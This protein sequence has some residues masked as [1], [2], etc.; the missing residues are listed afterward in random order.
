[1]RRLFVLIALLGCGASE[2][3]PNGASTPAATPAAACSVTG[4]VTRGDVPSAVPVH[5][6]ASQPVGERE[7]RGV[8]EDQAVSGSDGTFSFGAPCGS[9]VQLRFD[10]WIWANEPPEV[11][12][13]PAPSPLSVVLVPERAAHLRLED[14]AGNALTGELT[15]ITGEVL[16]VPPEGVEVVGL[17][18]GHIAGTITSAGHAPRTWRMNRSDEFAEVEPRHFEVTVRMGAEAPLWVW[19]PDPRDVAGVWC[20]VDGARGDG[21]KLRD[22]AWYCAC[23]GVDRV[24]IATKLWDVGLVREVEGKD[25]V[26]E[27]WPAPVKQCLIV[28]EGGTANIHPAGVPDRLLLGATGIASNLCV[29]LPKGEALEVDFGGETLPHMPMSPG[30]VEL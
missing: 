2:P 8:L 17:S 12:A 15:R 27:A 13:E 5:M 3:A 23:G 18:Y 14:V 28:G 1:M 11:T 16:A 20:I 19:V 10:G 21:C 30:E 29:T 24:G 7:F 4:V 6:R 26:V 25:L 22:G 9:R